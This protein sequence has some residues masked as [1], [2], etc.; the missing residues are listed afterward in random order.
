[1][2]TATGGTSDNFSDAEQREVIVADCECE[3]SPETEVVYW[4]VSVQILPR[5]EGRYSRL[6]HK[7]AWS[8]CVV[9]E[10]QVIQP[11]VQLLVKLR[12]EEVHMFCVFLTTN[13]TR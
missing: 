1:V 5:V 12:V 2:Q 9:S 7:A 4:E 11:P 10:G 3:L 6:R 8:V 13:I